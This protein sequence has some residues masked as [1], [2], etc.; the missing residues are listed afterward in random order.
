MPG[1][2]VADG[3]AEVALHQ[4]QELIAVPGIEVV[5]PFPADL[6]GTFLFSAGVTTA[7]KEAG[8]ARALI[9]FLRTQDATA[10][11]KAKGMDPATP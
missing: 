2:A 3:R 9:N 6:Q 1:Y 10:V 5:G 4:I 11:I 8:A 7:A